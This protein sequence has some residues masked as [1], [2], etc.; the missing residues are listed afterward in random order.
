M[1]GP[2]LIYADNAGDLAA[3]LRARCPGET[4][5]AVDRADALPGA[6]E[7]HRPEAV[8]SIKSLAL[9]PET[10]RPILDAPSVR[11]L[12]VGGSGYEHVAGW[13]AGRITLTNCV[14]VLAPFLAETVIGA[15][16]ALN[17]G[18]IR[19]HAQQRDRLWRSP[20]SGRLEIS[21][22]SPPP[23][24]VVG[25]FATGARSSC[26]RTGTAFKIPSSTTAN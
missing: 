2:I 3:G 25:R 9:G 10:H 20:P 8:F 13:D 1:S 21:W 26:S 24:T 15:L 17:C 18:L 19:Y 5:H 6:L 16:M 23:K 7:A 11:W 12:H 4:V 14:G 22:C